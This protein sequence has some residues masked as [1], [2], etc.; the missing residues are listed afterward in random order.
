[1]NC[2]VMGNI[3]GNLA[4]SSPCTQA[5][6]PSEGLLY[7]RLLAENVHEPATREFQSWHDEL[8]CSKY[9]DSLCSQHDR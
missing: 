5:A 7:D 3:G 1:M 4:R 8:V 6:E 9:E 2:N